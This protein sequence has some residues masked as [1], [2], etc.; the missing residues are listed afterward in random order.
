MKLIPLSEVIVSA[1]RQRR[2]FDAE[3]LQELSDSIEKFGLMHPLVVRPQGDQTILVAGERR[4][5]AISDIYALGAAIHFNNVEVPEGMVPVASLGELSPLEA[6]EAELEEN[7]RR[8]DLTWQESAS[9]LQRLHNLRAAQAAEV[10]KTQT[11]AD[12]AAEVYEG[13]R[14]GYYQDTVR[15]AVLVAKHLDD[16]DVA[17][18]KNAKDALKILVKKE[19]AAKNAELAATVGATFS[20]ADHRL[21]QSDCLEWMV[22]ADESQFDVIC[23]DPPYGMGADEFGD[24]AGK[25]VGTV[26][27][28]DDSAASFRSLMVLALPLITKVAKPAAH[29]YLFCDIE[30]FFFLRQQATENGWTPF[31]TPLVL[32]KI[33]SGRVP[34]PE[35]G[36]RRSYELVFYA[37]RG[38]KAVT[39]IYPDVFSVSGD[40]NLGHGAQKPVAAYV[41]L[42][43]RSVRPGDKVLD[44]FAG[45]GTIIPA[46]H[47]LKCYATAIEREAQYYGIAVNRAKELG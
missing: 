18:A 1:N 2:D 16:P 10:G 46:C 35:H 25:L 21:V 39:H 27:S 24:A 17:T 28:Y 23:T 11:F 42:L 38:G 7:I 22:D 20:A 36:P 14:E 12:T 47:E 43:R 34:L 4:L 44:P 19:T 31:R 9:A 33:N 8:R 40:D 5:R 45:T 37:F 13:K 26:H 15:T 29:L 30:Q 6:E 32:H 3:A 41:D